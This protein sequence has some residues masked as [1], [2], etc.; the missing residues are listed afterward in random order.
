ME[1]E[2]AGPKSKTK[3]PSLCPPI[4]D[5]S[6][7]NGCW[8]HGQH[9]CSNGVSETDSKSNLFCTDWSA[10][11]RGKGYGRVTYVLSRTQHSDNIQQAAPSAMMTIADGES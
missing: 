6:S 10:P 11:R 7:E 1:V 3:V 5:R 2:R 8:K 4:G 9:E